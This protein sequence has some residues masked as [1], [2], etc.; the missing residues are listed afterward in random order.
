K[1]I[2]WMKGMAGTGK[3][4]IARTIARKYHDE[5]CPRASF[6]FSKREDYLSKAG[7][8]FTSVAVQLASSSTT[9]KNGI[10]KA[11]AKR[12]DAFSDQWTQLILKSLSELKVSSSQPPFV[13]VVDALDECEN[14][15]DIRAILL[16]LHGARELK[17]LRLRIS[18]TSRPETGIRDQ[19]LGTEY[20]NLVLHNIASSII[21]HDI[22]TFFKYNIGIIRRNFSF[23]ADWPGEQTIEN[24]VCSAG[25]LFIWADT[26]CRFISD[27]GP[28]TKSRLPTVLKGDPTKG[29]EDKLNEIY[30]KILENSV[31]GEYDEM[32]RAELLQLLN[33]ILGT[34]VILFSSISVTSL[35]RL[36]YI[37]KEDL[38]Q[39]LGGL[40]SAPGVPKD[41]QYPIRLHHPSSRDFILDKQR[42]IER[43]WVDEKK[44]QESLAKNCL[45]LLSQ[46]LRRDICDLGPLGTQ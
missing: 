4:T 19:I 16:L 40:H 20:H 37:T 42:C 10:C 45:K 5:N 43:F 33:V 27:G 18:M 34:I 11:I 15:N 23:P 14:V 8:S 3:S 32:E 25:G 28:P 22:S 17:T 9:I 26:A 41:M 6:L 35:E 30:N 39:M 31:R 29:P 7:K 46:N 44:A 24:L 2:F 13:L 1:G 38:C 36:L 21:T 12:S